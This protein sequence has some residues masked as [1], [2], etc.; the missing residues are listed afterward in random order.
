MGNITRS[1]TTFSKA[2]KDAQTTRVWDI[3][4]EGEG[5]ISPHDNIVLRTTSVTGVPPKPEYAGHINV[6]LGGFTFFF[7]GKLNKHGELTIDVFEDIDTETFKF[8]S[9]IKAGAYK[10]GEEKGADNVSTKLSSDMTFKVTVRLGDE[11]G[12]IKKT[13][14]FTHCLVK[15]D[16]EPT[17]A[18]NQESEAVKASITFAYE[19]FT[20][21]NNGETW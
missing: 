7:N 1:F 18:L 6:P 12:A 19:Y 16:A 10:G 20:E 5:S 11:T 2:I 14:V 21:D 9:K 8:I 13:W 15:P 4:I 17:N 3:K